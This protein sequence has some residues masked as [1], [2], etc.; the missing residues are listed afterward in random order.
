MIV[1][2]NYNTFFRNANS[3]LPDN[4]NLHTSEYFKCHIDDLCKLRIAQRVTKFGF[5]IWQTCVKK[6]SQNIWRSFIQS[7]TQ[8]PISVFLSE[9]YKRYRIGLKCRYPFRHRDN[10]YKFGRYPCSSFNFCTAQLIGSI[11]LHFVVKWALFQL[12]VCTF[13]SLHMHGL[14]YCTH[15]H[16]HRGIFKFRVTDV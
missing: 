4:M 6:C 14:F 10:I 8:A 7:G 9:V 2:W 12:V 1:A 3:H 13:C 11:I 15:N 16:G 5:Q